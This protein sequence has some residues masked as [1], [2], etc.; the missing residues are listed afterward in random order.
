[1]RVNIQSALRALIII[2]AGMS[3]IACNTTDSYLRISGTP[4]VVRA[5]DKLTG[6]KQP[7]VNCL[8]G[9]HPRAEM[10]AGRRVTYNSDRDDRPWTEDTIERDTY[11]VPNR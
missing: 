4:K 1:M 9:Y 7:R 6:G 3:T 11:C 5:V 10:S 8:A 2:G